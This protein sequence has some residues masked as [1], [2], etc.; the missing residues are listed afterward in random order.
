M[1]LKN[2]FFVIFALVLALNSRAELINSGPRWIL[3]EG[4]TTAVVAPTSLS[5]LLNQLNE[6]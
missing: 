4:T 2:K 1:N 5:E 6:A 3:K